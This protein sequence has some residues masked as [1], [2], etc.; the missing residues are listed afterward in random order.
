MTTEQLE[1]LNSAVAELVR[2]YREYTAEAGTQ[3]LIDFEESH[4][5]AD[6]FEDMEFY[7]DEAGLLG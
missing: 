5:L 6:L 1:T 3:E 7:V 4:P 2:M